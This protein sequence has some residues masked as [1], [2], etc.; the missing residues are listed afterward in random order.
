MVDSEGANA[1][2]AD[3][4]ADTATSCADVTQGGQDSVDADGNVIYN[5]RSYEICDAYAALVA[6]G[7]TCV[8]ET[9]CEEVNGEKCALDPTDDKYKCKVAGIADTA[10]TDVD[11]Y[12]KLI[13]PATT[14][15]ATPETYQY[16]EHAD[17]Y[18]AGSEWYHDAATGDYPEKRAGTLEECK[19]D[20]DASEACVGISYIIDTDHVQHEGTPC[21][22]VTSTDVVWTDS[23]TLGLYMS[24]EKGA[25]NND[26]QPETTN[27][28]AVYEY[29][30]SE[31]CDSFAAM[32]QAEMAALDAAKVC[33]P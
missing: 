23:P 15:P 31:V 18:G 28:D 21:I 26:A 32:K 16:T 6:S 9:D 27:D 7:L 33:S 5:Y 3:F 10:C 11:T 8:Q 14:N 20:C 22:I 25:S 17:K 19:A 24:Y 2:I 13:T 1:A 12:K 30:S 4:G 29:Y